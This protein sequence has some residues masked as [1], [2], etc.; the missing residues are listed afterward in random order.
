MVTHNIGQRLFA[1]YVMNQVVKVFDYLI[2]SFQFLELVFGRFFF[3][4]I[5]N[6]LL[7]FVRSWNAD[8]SKFCYIWAKKKCNEYFH[9][10]CAQNF[11][12]AVTRL[13][14]WIIVKTKALE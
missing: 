2:F 1:K 7:I 4:F 13:S 14:Q 12:F 10:E 9:L 8:L 6:A 5:F 11:F 3:D